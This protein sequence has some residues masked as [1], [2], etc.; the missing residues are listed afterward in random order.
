MLKES[1]KPDHELLLQHDHPMP[2]WRNAV[3]HSEKETEH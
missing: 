3:S 2:I 1:E